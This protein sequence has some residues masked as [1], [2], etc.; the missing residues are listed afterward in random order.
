MIVQNGWMLWEMLFNREILL[1]IDVG[2][3]LLINKG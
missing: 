2:D 3:F 1:N